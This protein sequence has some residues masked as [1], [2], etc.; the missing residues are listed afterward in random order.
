[1]GQHRIFSAV[2]PGDFPVQNALIACFLDQLAN[3]PYDPERLVRIAGIII[4]IPGQHCVPIL[5][6]VPQ[7]FQDFFLGFFRPVI[8]QRHGDL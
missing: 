1:M 5:K 3:G 8:E 6:L 2:L 4:R 7:A